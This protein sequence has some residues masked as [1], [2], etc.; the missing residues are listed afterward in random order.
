MKKLAW[1]LPFLFSCAPLVCP[2][3][4]AIRQNYQQATAPSSYQASLS[5]RYGLIRAPLQVQKKEGRFT[6]ESQSGEL[7]LDRLCVA[8]ACLEVPINPDGVLFGKVLKGGEKVQCSKAGLV[9]QSEEGW[10]RLR[11]VFKEGRLNQVEVLDTKNNRVL[12]L[13][14][15]DW[16]K[17]GYAR[18]IKVETEGLSLLL[19]VDSLKF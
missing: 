11:H 3:A 18:A 14:Y 17:E 5:I 4:D 19:T 7:S 9:F 16:A 1:A 8:G 12:R 2:E 15:L 10:L 13:N 6:V